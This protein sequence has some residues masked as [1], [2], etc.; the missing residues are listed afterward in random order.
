MPE[1]TCKLCGFSSIWLNGLTFHVSSAHEVKRKLKCEED[2]FSSTQHYWGTGILKSN[3]QVYINALM[4]IEEAMVD[5]SSKDEE[6]KKLDI[7]W[8]EAGNPV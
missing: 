1:Y 3:L 5:D 7:L 6:E 8:K 2:V 4:D